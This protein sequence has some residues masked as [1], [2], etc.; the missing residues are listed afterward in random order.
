MQKYNTEEAVCKFLSLN[1][2]NGKI[3]SIHE[4]FFEFMRK[5]D[6]SGLKAVVTLQDYE[7]HKMYNRHY[8][9]C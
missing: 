9:T 3:I 6:K 2:V 4:N 8:R 1:D 5:R 7:Q